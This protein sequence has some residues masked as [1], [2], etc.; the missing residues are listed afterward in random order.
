MRFQPLC[1]TD[2]PWRDGPEGGLT[3]SAF[4]L[5]PLAV[6]RCDFAKATAPL[7]ST[8]R[9]AAR[10]AVCAGPPCAVGGIRSLRRDIK[11]VP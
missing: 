7:A 3:G 11:S 1:L 8:D 9:Q 5:M 10:T 2:Q 4:L 6:D